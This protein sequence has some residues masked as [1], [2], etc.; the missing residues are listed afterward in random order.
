MNFMELSLSWQAASRSFIQEF[1]NV[2]RNPKNFFI[3]FE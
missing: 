1:T 2:L 3:K